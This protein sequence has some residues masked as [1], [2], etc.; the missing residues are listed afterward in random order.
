MIFHNRFVS[1]GGV[2]GVHR[3]GGHLHHARISTRRR[4]PPARW[5]TRSAPARR[6]SRRPTGMRRNCS[7]DERGR[8]RAVRDAPA[9]AEGVNHFLSNPTLH[10]GDAQARV[11]GGPRDDLAG[12]GAALHGELRA[13]A[14]R[15]QRAVDRARRR[16]A[17]SS[18]AN[19]PMP[20][21]EARSLLRMSD[22]TGI[23]QHAIYNVP[24]YHEGYCTDDNARAFIF[25]VLLQEAR[26]PRAGDS[27]GCRAPTS[28]S[29]G[30]PSTRTPAASAIS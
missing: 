7:P 29:C 11:E 18:N 28:P 19:Y 1:A 20:A 13:G 24:N 21:A 25:T 4:S 12:G 6:S 16:C 30:M 27:T 17:R 5:P 3:R 22:H 8:A 2:E 15:P 23:F 26:G 14:R 9:I 10:D